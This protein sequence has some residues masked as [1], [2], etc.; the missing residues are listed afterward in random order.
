MMCL[1]IYIEV[2]LNL[3]SSRKSRIGDK[4][5]SNKDD[6]L[7]FK[8]QTAVFAHNFFWKVLFPGIMGKTIPMLYN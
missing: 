2:W 7:T 6:S 5:L 8:T 3:Y 4:M 1:A